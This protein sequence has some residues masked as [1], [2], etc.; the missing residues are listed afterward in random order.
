MASPTSSA[1][2]TLNRVVAGLVAAAL[3]AG[4]PDNVTFVVRDAE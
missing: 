2:P 3:D 1:T 4:A